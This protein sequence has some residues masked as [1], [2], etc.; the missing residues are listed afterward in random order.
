MIVTPRERPERACR[1]D[2]EHTLCISDAVR[3]SQT[4]VLETENLVTQQANQ[5][6]G[7]RRWPPN[8]GQ[9][10]ATPPSIP[11]RDLRAAT[12]PAP[13]SKD[14]KASRPR[15][16]SDR[17]DLV[18]LVTL[19]RGGDQKAWGQL[20]RRFDPMLRRLAHSYRLTPTDID[21]V[22]QATWL[23]MFT[24]IEHLREPAAIRQ[25]LTTIMRRECLRL[26]QTPIREHLTDDPQP[27]Y[28]A[29][30]AGPEADL[31]AGERRTVLLRALNTLPE[32]ERRLLSALTAEPAPS[33]RH[34]SAT[35]GIPVGSI[36]PTRA[37][38]LALLERH[39][40]VRSVRP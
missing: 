14:P 12:S 35:L 17:H 4:R 19:A 11:D 10:E 33:Y 23:R 8:P 38:A 30:V 26:L 20:I 3:G 1:C 40:A 37:R 36:G 13:A 25:W 18:A 28:P 9:D 6:V 39:P 27:D 29:I 2:R 16:A 15:P 31:L 32:R 21:D 7:I 24:R 22:V 34:V 5:L